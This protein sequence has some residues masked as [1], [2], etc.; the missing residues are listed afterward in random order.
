MITLLQTAVCFSGVNRMSE[1]EG[2]DLSS[3]DIF[4]GISL[5]EAEE[6]DDKEYNI[7]Q[8][9]A[10]PTL[11]SI[12]SEDV[13][14][15]LDVDLLLSE[16]L[17][18]LTAMPEDGSNTN[19]V[20]DEER[21]AKDSTTSEWIKEPPLPA[22]KQ[23]AVLHHITLKGLS[24]QITSAANKVDA[25][26]PT[27]M[28]VCGI[29]AIGT[30]NGL[31]LIFDPSQVLKLCLGSTSL[32]AQYGAISALSL[33]N[34]CTQIVSGFT[35]GQILQWDLE[36]GKLLRTITNVLPH[37]TTVLNIKFTDD[38][39]VAVCSDSTGSVFELSFKRSMGTKTC[40]ARCLFSSD[41][42]QVCCVEPLRIP[43]YF[44]EHPAAQY[45]LVAM[46]SLKKLLV[47]SLKPVL[48]VIHASP[49][50]KT[51]PYCVP[52][53]AWHFMLIKE[54]DD[55]VLAF[56]RGSS[57][58]LFHVKC[59]GESLECVKIME[60][61]HQYDIVNVKWMNSQTLLL[62]D[63]LDKLHILDRESQEE[64]ELLDLSDMQL[65]HTSSFL[66]PLTPGEHISPTLAE[67]GEKSTYQ[68]V[69]THGGETVLLGAKSVHVVSL[70]TWEERI[71]FLVKQ[72]CFAEALGLAWVFFNGTA[73]AV[74]G[75][76]GKKQKKKAIVANKVAKM[77]LNYI[78]IS[79]RR[80]PEQGKLEI[81]EEHFQKTIPLCVTCCFKFNKTDLLFG[82]VYDKL[83]HNAVALGVLFECLE[84]YILADRLKDIT[85]LVVKE[86]VVYY[87]N[88]GMLD[89][90]ESLITHLDITTLDL[91]QIVLL[92]R[93]YKLFDALIY[94]YNKGMNDFITPIEEMIQAMENALKS[95]NTDELVAVGNKILVYISCSLTG[96]AYPLGVISED[97]VPVVKTEVFS[98]LT[99]LHSKN[100]DPDEGPHPYIRTLLKCNTREFLNVLALTF[101][102][103]QQY[104]QAVEFLQIITDV[105]LKVMLESVDFTPSQIGCLFTFL[106]RQIAKTE[107]ALFVNMQL[108]D[109][110]LDFLC[111]PEDGTRHTERQQALLELLQAGGAIYFDEDKLLSMAEK[112][113]FYQICEFVYEERRLYT[114]I[115]GCYLK[116]AARRDQVFGYINDVITRADLTNEEKIAFQN[117]VFCNI[118]ELL[119]LSPNRTAM[120]I[121]QKF[122]D[123][124]PLI[125]ETLQQDS[126]L[127]FD[128]LHGIFNPRVEQWPFKDASLLNHEFHEM[129]IE[130]L[131]QNH[132]DQVL[133]F[134]KLSDLYRPE[135]AVKIVQKHQV[136]DALAFLLEMQGN[137]QGAF[138]VLLEHMKSRLHTLTEC[139]AS[140]MGK[141]GPAIHSSDSGFVQTVP[142]LLKQII[143][144]C[145]RASDT[146]DTQQKEELW[147]PLLDLLMSPAEHL[148]SSP[149]DQV[150]NSMKA[151]TKDVLE[152]MAAY[153][154][155]T[156][157]LQ[158]LIQDP[159]YSV[160]NYGEIKGIIL[161][162]LDTFVYEKT[163]LEA[164]K[165]LLN[166]DL[167][168][169]LCS[170]RATVTRGLTPAHKLCGV[171]TQQYNKHRAGAKI[172]VFSCGH[173]YHTACLQSSLSQQEGQQGEWAC[174]KCLSANKKWTSIT[175]GR[176]GH[177]TQLSIL[178][179]L[180]RQNSDGFT[181]G[182]RTDLFQQG[183]FQL[184]LAPPPL[185]D[186]T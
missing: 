24:A 129:Y 33:N 170:L 98:C 142:S 184:K 92:T 160:G 46:V 119:T 11:E 66:R 93:K 176:V 167:H 74:F 179:E 140:V 152:G 52:V 51:D 83:N 38:P 22:I 185:V 6:L 126:K 73:K 133:G 90:L 15:D 14:C 99:R 28:A 87:E 72:D 138:S 80:C 35:K 135:E 177:K 67:I 75:L 54:C 19:T 79:L 147:F 171:C 25:G 81:M 31:I 65:I 116:D 102:D 56:C 40:E 127:L 39:S 84:P 16:E 172:I 181:L 159:V 64:M 45:S 42:G 186:S 1:N 89:A 91:H 77:L 117:E 165:S 17:S 149:P 20:K 71:N 12:L 85:P 18:Q 163:L 44:L 104:S 109:Q 108:F 150:I 105:L 3:S 182:G 168:W 10:P 143:G 130:L 21:A 36:T 9:E 69:C 23:E 118:Q 43:E 146:L 151:L 76:S 174:L 139:G 70:R 60:A 155:L 158:R 156:D 148:Q 157:I 4:S 30:S 13:L 48:H 161:G 106:A 120:L 27:A 115:V 124:I 132:S 37:G 7:P 32:G 175:H 136:Y 2:E 68:S 61:N 78:E 53:L 58:T 114:S 95:E 29:I 94:V 166:Q 47:I 63:P 121:L 164:T 110:V 137:I 49:F 82:E 128:F 103:M 8:V 153:I 169:S 154:P 123:S 178:T 125:M 88:G 26:T 97:L 34:D 86:L 180:A 59:T 101:E 57:M 131:C 50:L 112:M 5:P 145:Q 122:Q 41:K 183:D 96:R 55:P 107:N 173:V 100:A 162:M 141:E 113:Q 62:I 111:N 134:L 144:F